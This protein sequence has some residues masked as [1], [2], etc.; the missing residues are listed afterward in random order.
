MVT[1]VVIDGEPKRGIVLRAPSSVRCPVVLAPDA[2]LRLSLGFWGDGKGV[3]EVR[4]L[5]DGEEPETVLERKVTGGGGA[6]W[7]GVNRELSAYAGRVLTL[8]LRT[9]QASLGGRV[10]FGDP[11]IVR[12]KPNI[13]QTPRATTAVLVVLSA[14]DRRRVPPWG[15]AGGLTSLAELAKGGAAFSSYRIPTTVSGSVI[16]SMLTGLPPRA[17]ALEDPAARLAAATRLINEVVK[18]ASGRTAMFTGAPSTFSAFGFDTGWDRYEML[19]PVRD[20][21]AAEPL[22]MAARWLETELTDQRDGRRLVVVHARGAHP[23]WDVPKEDVARLPPEEYGGI[24]DARRGGIMLAKVR[25]R[26]SRAQ[27]RLDDQDWVRLRALERASLLPQDAALGR[28]IAVLKKKNEWDRTLLIV[29]GD[30]AP[31][32]GPEPPY[33][34]TASLAEDRLLVP[35]LVKFPEGKFAAKDVQSDVTS[36]DIAATIL[37]ALRLAPPADWAARDLYE[38]AAGFEP[39]VGRAVMATLAD[40]YSTRFG[41]YRLAGQ[42][43]KTPDLCQLDIDPACVSDILETSP[44]AAQAIWQW[45]F[46]AETTALDRRVAPREPASIDPDVGAALT[47]WGDI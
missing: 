13:P 9:D 41:C 30:I 34:P 1:D 26:R 14:I 38:A 5:A 15:P 3:A 27:R 45:T 20:L 46:R 28:L 11:A 32:E 39:L 25:N 17:H 24:L 10:V 43:G 4:I 37:H 35:L 19:S 47:V 44:T 21:P 22:S 18:Q 29:V 31:G 2:S 16:A 36:V 8:E 33:D 12:S 23:P 6:T 40:R 42:L 7:I